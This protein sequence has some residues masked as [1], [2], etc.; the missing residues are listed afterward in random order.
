MSLPEL[1]KAFNE[2]TE[3]T[4][5]NDIAR[6]WTSYRDKNTDELIERAEKLSG[7]FPFILAAVHAHIARLPQNGFLGKPQETLLEIIEETGSDDF[8][9]IFRQFTKREGI[10][11]FGDLQVKRMLDQIRK[12]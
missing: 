7:K 8:P 4:N 9:T 6:L 1:R 2:K 12:N 3:I 5:L 11:G 10:Y